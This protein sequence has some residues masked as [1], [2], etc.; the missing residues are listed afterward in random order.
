MASAG[1]PRIGGQIKVAIPP[2]MLARIDGAAKAEGV[3]RSTWIRAAIAARLY[4][5]DQ[6]D[7][8]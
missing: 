6:R 5:H 1:R 8:R 2:D 4:A 7:E 3:D